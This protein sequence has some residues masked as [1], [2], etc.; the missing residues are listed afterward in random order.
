[1]YKIK[2]IC[3]CWILT[4]YTAIRP[5]SERV[6]HRQWVSLQSAHAVSK[7]VCL[8][9]CDALLY[10]TA[11]CQ[12]QR[13]QSVQNAATRMVT[14]LRRMEHVTPILKSLYWLPIR[15]RVTYKLATL[16]HKCIFSLCS[17]FFRFLMSSD[18]DL[19][20]LNWKLALH[21]LIPI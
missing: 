19:R 13:L 21:S 16:V 11:D 2:K 6:R 20:P 8:D 1:M 18:I 15:Q 5:V 7:H 12:L 17:N 4:W 3:W 10:G 9:Y 14:G